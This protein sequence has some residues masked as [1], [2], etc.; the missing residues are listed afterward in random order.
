MMEIRLRNISDR[1]G[2]R[3]KAI[4]RVKHGQSS[5]QD[6]LKTLLAQEESK[7]TPEELDRIQALYEVLKN[8]D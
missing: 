5:M 3:L 6:F 7:Y 2:E 4:A 1:R 8:D